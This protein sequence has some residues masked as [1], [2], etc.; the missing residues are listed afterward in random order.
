MTFPLFGAAVVPS[1]LILWFFHSRDRHPE[2]RAVLLRT[3]WYG[4]LITV[5][6]GLAE[7]ALGSAA[8]PL[9]LSPVA[10]SLNAAFL[11]AALCEE[12]LKF[13]IVYRYC[14]RLAA[15]DE[16]IDGIVY[17]VTASLGFATLENILYVA[18]NGMEVAMLRAVLAV[19]GHACWGA[20]MGYYIGQAEFGPPERRRRNLVLA[21]AWPMA[22]HG[23]YDFPLMWLD[24]LSGDKAPALPWLWLPLAALLLGWRLALS[25]LKAL[26]KDQLPASGAQPLAEPAAVGAAQP[27]WQAVLQ[28]LLGG[29]LAW[30]GGLL[31][32]AVLA[33]AA[34]QGV[35]DDGAALIVGTAVVGGLPLALGL[36]LFRRGLRASAAVRPA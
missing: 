1:L 21:L 36:W 8:E 16:P 30:G 19:P 13:L 34:L 17:G 32:L 27:R 2:P 20:L 12:T 18:A 28:L 23:L 9:A 3:F 31:T 35:G 14:R 33:G 29:V 26:R 7:V 15:F 25:Q 6:A 22:L 4:V 10:A 5:P 11:G 24:R